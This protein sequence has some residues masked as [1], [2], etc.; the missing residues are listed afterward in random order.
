ML[1]PSAKEILR[2]AFPFA[3]D[4]GENAAPQILTAMFRHGRRRDAGRTCGCPSGAPAQNPKIRRSGSSPGLEGD[5]GGS[6]A[7]LSLLESREFHARSLLLR[8]AQGNDLANP[9]PELFQGACLRIAAVQDGSARQVVTVLILLD[10]HRELLRPAC[11]ISSFRGPNYSTVARGGW[12]TE[13]SRAAWKK[14]SG[15]AVSARHAR[16][17]F[18]RA[19]Q[20]TSFPCAS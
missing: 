1:T 20:R 11:T 3:K 6:T 4:F 14:C 19:K 5:G 16:D 18:R 9:R 8:Q 15:K 10:D 2:H 7:D 17:I 12:H 13:K